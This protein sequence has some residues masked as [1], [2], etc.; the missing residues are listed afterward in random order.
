MVCLV[1]YIAVL[2]LGVITPVM[3]WVVHDP[4]RSVFRTYCE[5]LLTYVIVLVFAVF[6]VGA[7]F[8]G[9]YIYTHCPFGV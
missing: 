5:I 2:I 9:E 3:V 6:L 1:V 4:H 8:V 7:K